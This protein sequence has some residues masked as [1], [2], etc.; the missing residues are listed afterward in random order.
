MSSVHGSSMQCNRKRPS[1]K[2]VIVKEP[3]ALPEAACSVNVMFDLPGYGKA[4]AT[5]R[6]ANADE[7][8]ANLAST[9]AATRA[10]LAPVPAAVAV[11]VE[12][13]ALSNTQRVAHMLACGLDKAMARQD[14]ALVERLS[15]AAA[16]VLGGA[17][18]PGE[19]DGLLT[20]RSQA[21]PETWY[22]VEAG[23]CT[24]KDWSLHTKAGAKFCCKHVLSAMM[25]TRL[26]EP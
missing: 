21:E 11:V 15:K 14:V 4:Q 18:A 16:L 20:V 12:P 8:A 19:R 17:V 6:G 5:G 7:A 10:A 1:S 22:S 13:P 24:C 9:I 3:G 23:Q 26:A 25:Y 2:V